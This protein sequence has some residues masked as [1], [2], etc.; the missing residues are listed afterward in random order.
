MIF[1]MEK[2]YKIT[3]PKGVSVDD[4]ETSVSDGVLSVSVE[5]VKERYMP[6]DGDFV[7]CGNGYRQWVIIY[8]K[9]E[10]APN[11]CSYYYLMKNVG[12]NTITF[13]NYCNAQETLRP[14]TNEERKELLDALAKEG[15]RWNAEK[16]CV[17]DLPRW[18]AEAGGVYYVV[19]EH[20]DVSRT[21]EKY[22]SYDKWLYDFGN[23]FR[24]RE[25]AEKAAE[26]IRDIFKNSKAE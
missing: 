19:N 14:A 24:T 8:K 25:A 9:T 18:R 7:T 2:T 17:E 11:K 1:D 26:K 20:G 15:K 21:E 23:Y 6:K 5:M 3:L 4:I 22:A 16:K 13:D 12:I 10:H